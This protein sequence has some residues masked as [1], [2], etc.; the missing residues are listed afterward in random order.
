MTNIPNT[1]KAVR[2][3]QYGGPEQL[4]LEDI[5]VPQIS[6]DEV[7][8]KIHAAGVNPV[9]WKIRE[10]HLSEMLGHT[11][12]LTL[13]WDV[14]GEVVAKGDA[15]QNVN[16][17]DGVYSRPEIARNGGY[18]EYIA[19]KAAEVAIKPQSLSWAE[20]AAVPLAALTAWQA[21]YEFAELKSGDKVLIHAGAGGVGHLAIQ[22][23]KLKGAT[24]YTTA[25][26]GNHAFVTGLGADEVIDYRNEDFTRLKD[27]DV[28]FD[29][30]GGEVQEK[31]WQCIKAGGMMVSI[32]APPEEAK[33]AQHNAKGAFCFVQPSNSQLTELAA[34]FDAGKLKIEVAEILPLAQAAGALAKSESGKTRGKLVLEVG[35]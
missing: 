14:A 23:A 32:V 21:L 35:K 6:A 34:L 25:S 8:I 7:L 24:V 19:V 4:E 17:G 18:A 1:M 3:H 11:L 2:I 31:S 16:L 13:G 30:V 20:A 22:L 5:A 28:I 9:D 27:M 26:K 10:G 12:P 33:A 29:T 15:V